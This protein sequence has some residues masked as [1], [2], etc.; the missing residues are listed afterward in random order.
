M[1]LLPAEYGAPFSSPPETE[2]LRDT[3]PDLP[4]FA[5][6]RRTRWASTRDCLAID[7][8]GYI[9]PIEALDA[10]RVFA[11]NP[12]PIYG[13]RLS[14]FIAGPPGCGKST[15]VAAIV[16]HF[17]RLPIYLFSEVKE[18]RAFE[19]LKLRR[20]HMDK[21]T[22]TDLSLDNITK[23]GSCFCVFDD[24]D[25][26]RDPAIAKLIQGLLD[27]IIANGRSHGGANI[28]VIMTCHALN[29]YKRTKY[30]QENCN[31]WVFFPKDCVYRQMLNLLKKEGREEI[32]PAI[33]NEKR[34]FFHHASPSFIALSNG[35]IKL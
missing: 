14:Y 15:T 27:N 3:S 28:H 6:L 13:E 10:H 26:I 4:D 33:R 1:E 25:K 12:I 24:V 30:A 34:I 29:D 20:V 35:I 2:T 23:D 9:F 32:L 16:R 8:T 11:R 7:D 31:Y 17:P 19:G 21:K 5:T 22:L 18:D